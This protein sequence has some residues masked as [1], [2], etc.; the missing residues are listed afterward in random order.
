V[1]I[2]G[3]HLALG[4][5]V[6]AQQYV[7]RLEALE[8]RPRH[9]REGLDEARLVVEV[10]EHPKRRYIRAVCVERLDPRDGGARGRLGVLGEEGQED[11]AGDA[12]RAQGLEGG[13]QVRP[14]VAHPELDPV[15]V[16]EGAGHGVAQGEP[17]D[18]QRRSGLGPDLPVLGCRG[19]GSGAQNE[20]VEEEP[21][22]QGGNVDHPR[23]RQELRQV[24]PH[25][26][27]LRSLRRAQ[28]HEK[29]A[30]R[31][32]ASGHRRTRSQPPSQAERPM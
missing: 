16:A 19:P 1:A 26:A 28:V 11:D 17:V 8:V 13:G 22:G 32:V 24:A 9:R 2:G 12:G 14:S 20:A 31:G 30:D 5:A 10:A 27:R 21:A 15:G 25:F 23:V 3:A 29:D 6:V 4:E 18:E 7:I